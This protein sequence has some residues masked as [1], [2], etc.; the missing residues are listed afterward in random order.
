MTKTH[1]Q[2]GFITFEG[3]EG[4]GKTT[5]VR[6][7]FEY[8]KKRGQDVIMTREPG[9]SE[10]A[11]KIRSIILDK[12][13]ENITAKTEVLLY[14]AARAQ[15]LDE[16]IKPA[17]ERGQTV[18]CDRYTDSTYAYQGVARGIGGAEVNELNRLTV[19]GFMPELT[20]FLDCHPKVA[21]ARKGGF[22]EDDRIEREGMEFHTKVYGGYKQIAAAEPQRFVCVDASGTKAETHEKVLALLRSRGITE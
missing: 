6:L 13:N 15:H 2:R 16:I 8:M 17:L 22:D 4:V 14:L 18:L 20:I 12:E 9:G 5:Q 11:E 19:G 7:V 10:V 1:G 21:F 3:C